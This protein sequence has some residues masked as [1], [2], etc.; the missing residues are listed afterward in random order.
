MF[1]SSVAWSGRLEFFDGMCFFDLDGGC[2]FDVLFRLL[3]ES[4]LNVTMKK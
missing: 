1:V 3:I 2:G 4:P